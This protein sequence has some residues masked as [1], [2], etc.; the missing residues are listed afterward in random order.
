[1][2]RPIGD[3]IG[4]MSRALNTPEALQTAPPPGGDLERSTL[5]LE[6]ALR[7]SGLGLIEA[8][9]Q[10]KLPA[11]DNLLVV[12]DQFEEL[13]RFA[14]AANSPSQADDAAAFVKLLLEASSQTEIPIYIVITMRSDFIGDCA[15]FPDLAENVT[16]GMYLIPRMNREQR[17]SAIADPVGVGGGCISLRLVNRLLNEVGDNPDQLPVLQHALMRTWEHWVNRTRAAE[18]YENDPI[19]FEDYEAIGGLKNALSN[20]A[21]EAYHALPSERHRQIAKRMFQCLTEK[22]ADNREIRRPTS[23]GSLATVAGASN[24][25]VLKVVNEFHRQGRSF[26]TVPTEG[27]L[28]DD[29]LIDIS[30]E[31]LIRLWERLRVWVSEESESARMYRRVAD[32]ATME[33]RHE[34]I[35]WAGPLLASALDWRDKTK[36]TPEWAKR[37]D[38]KFHEA[39][40]FLEKSQRSQRLR[41]FAMA[42]LAAVLV[43]T[44]GIIWSN[45]RSAALQAQSAQLAARNAQL[46]AQSAQLEMQSAQLGLLKETEARQHSDADAKSQEERAGKMAARL[47]IQ[48]L[49]EHQERLQVASHR[50]SLLDDLM[51]KSTPHEA[52]GYHN[53][54]AML[55]AQQERLGDAIAEANAALKLVP[56]STTAL[57]TRGY[58]FVLQNNPKAALSD[59][60]QIRRIDPKL[61]LNYLN[62]TIVLAQLGRHADAKNALEL[63]IRYASHGE[64]TGGEEDLLPDEI[65]AATGRAVL[66]ANAAVFRQALYYLRPVL[67][68]YA[69]QANFE[70]DLRT[71]QGQVEKDG[72]RPAEKEDAALVAI[73]WAWLLERTKTPNYGLAV[74]QAVLWE[75][76]DYPADAAR[77]FSTFLRLDEE[78]KEARYAPLVSWVRGH[79]TWKEVEPVARKPQAAEL[80]VQAEASKA[81]QQYQKAENEAS[82]AISLEPRNVRLYLLRMGILFDAADKPYWGYRNALDQIEK[83]DKDIQKLEDEK[84]ASANTQT[85]SNGLGQ[86]KES[87]AEKLAKLEQERKA[88]QATVE[89]NGKEMRELYRRLLADCLKVLE[90]EPD[91]PLVYVFRAAAT[92]RIGSPSG[93]HGAVISDL[94]HALELN[95]RDGSALDWLSTVEAGESGQEAAELRVKRDRW[96]PGDAENLYQLADLQNRLGKHQDAYDTIRKAI[97]I[98]PASW[99]YYDVLDAAEKGLGYSAGQRQRERA[100]YD[101]MVAEYLRRQGSESAQGWENEHWTI[102]SELVDKVGGEE[103]RCNPDMTVCTTTKLTREEGQWGLFSIKSVKETGPDTRLVEINHGQDSGIV[104]GTAGTVFSR[105]TWDDN[106]K[107]PEVQ[108]GTGEVLSVSAE[109]ALVR[110]KL[111]KPEGPGLVRVGDPVGLGFRTPKVEHRSPLWAVTKFA[112]GL[113]DQNNKSIVDFDTLYSKESLELDRHLYEQMLND[114]H[115][116]GRLKGDTLNEGKPVSAGKMA[117]KRMREILDAA[118]QEDLDRLLKYMTTFPRT[119]FGHDWP[120]S[121]LYANW[122]A[123]GMPEQ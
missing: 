116:Y 47:R 36:P 40:T 78:R 9:K 71:A 12:V 102:L 100:E 111:L 42:S 91:T 74:G 60:E 84:K 105:Y 30:H 55:L 119:L 77:Y 88:A 75:E 67:D 99:R 57:T 38:A 13:F 83:D 106:D 1:V 24:S 122:A 10:A 59:F 82:Q 39:M 92:Y 8:V 51:A 37:Y 2:F 86:S 118:N 22:T 72:V 3:P 112:I 87:T 104:A 64:N 68:A 108:I 7:R 33:A 98:N 25:D 120:V 109:S 56:D 97:A 114:I 52:A 103:V 41:R 76:A 93:P 70:A 50:I 14:T 31:S 48:A 15:R 20:H 19:D 80:E 21:D 123:L 89:K 43:I 69:G 61:S 16:A 27:E 4:N 101:R 5:L 11:G 32:A 17:R 110:V 65:H 45:I 18:S 26:L 79:G 117:G 49:R 23:V 115:E 6:A 54:K 96:Y 44:A 66:Y 58:A 34:G 29:A 113:L 53:S 35:L 28:S 46:E 107:R 62:L 73:T 95:P 94:K 90:F 85:P 121:G 63:A 81:A